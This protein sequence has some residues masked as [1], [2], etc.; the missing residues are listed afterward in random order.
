VVILPEKETLAS[1][2]G[3]SM[4]HLNR[5]LKDLID[6]NTIGN[7]YPGVRIKNVVNLQKLID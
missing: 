7:G 6:E 2:L 4:R 3:T 5:V 1:M